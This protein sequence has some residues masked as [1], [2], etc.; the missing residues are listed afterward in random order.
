MVLHLVP[1]YFHVETAIKHLEIYEKCRVMR[2]NNSIIEQLQKETPLNLIEASVEPGYFIVLFSKN[3]KRLISQIDELPSFKEINETY[4]L[5]SEV[6]R[7]S[8]V[9]T[10]DQREYTLYVK[11]TLHFESII[12]EIFYLLLYNLIS[13]FAVLL[14]LITYITKYHQKI[15]RDLDNFFKDAVHEIGTPMGVLQINLDTLEQS[16]PES[17]VLKRSQAALKSLISIYESME[18]SLKREYVTYTKEQ[19]NLSEY[20]LTRI[21]FFSIFADLRGLSLTLSVEPNLHVRMNRIELQR[22]IDNNLSNAIKYADDASAIVIKLTLLEEHLAELAFE[23][24][25]N[26]I[27][28]VEKIFERNYRDF[29]FSVK[30]SGIGLHIVKQICDKY[31]IGV[32]VTSTMEGHNRFAYRLMLSHAL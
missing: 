16:I 23:S 22:L 11:R 6:W 31:H 14:L 26:P 13:L 18:Y 28:D 7:K 17:K 24:Q 30:G 5:G 10:L 4:V 27:S 32:S 1:G 20:L 19:I 8:A 21:D 12:A 9:V 15:N 25:G 3:N 29:N 2:I